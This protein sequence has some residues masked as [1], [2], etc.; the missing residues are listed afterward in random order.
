MTE[1]DKEQLILALEARVEELQ[2]TL[3]GREAEVG[4]IRE[5]HDYFRDRVG[6]LEAALREIKNEL[7]VPDENYPAPVANAVDIADRALDGETPVKTW[8]S[9]EEM[10]DEKYG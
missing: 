5:A 4:L 6:V 1:Q 3:V 9:E 8:N 10:M 7:G 2:R